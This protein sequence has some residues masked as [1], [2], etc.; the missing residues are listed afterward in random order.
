VTLCRLWLLVTV[1]VAAGG[2][3]SGASATPGDLDPS[4]SRD[5]FLRLDIGGRSAADAVAIDGAS[6][7]VVAATT[8][9]LSQRSLSVARLNAN[10]RL[11]RGFAHD[12]IAE[13]EPD[14]VALGDASDIGLLPDGRVVVAAAGGSEIVVSRL[15]ADGRPDPSFAGDGAVEISFGTP[16]GVGGIVVAADGT[17]SVAGSTTGV[18][19]RSSGEIVL[20]QLTPFGEL[21]SSYSGDGVATYRFPEATDS[22]A[23]GIALQSDGATLVA[24]SG[25]AGGETDLA[26]ARFEPDGDLDPTFSEDG[27]VRL[28][29][30]GD[31]D[32]SS[33]VALDSAGRA[34]LAGCCSRG[35]LRLE[36]DGDVDQTFAQGGSRG[37]GFSSDLL[38]LDAVDRINTIL[39][40]GGCSR[41]C[42]DRN[43]VLARLN[44]DGSVDRRFSGDGLVSQ[45][46][47]LHGDAAYD[48]AIQQNGRIVVVGQS[49]R[50]VLV[51]RHEVSSGK[52]DADG[53][54]RRDRAD[55]CPTRYG[56]TESGCPKFSRT[57][58]FKRSRAAD[59]FSGRLRSRDDKCVNRRRIEVRLELPGFD[60]ILRE[61]TT[62]VFGRW[63]AD[64]ALSPGVYYAMVDSDFRPQ[65]GKCG[66]ARSNEITIR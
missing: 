21:D 50:Q 57:L 30:E 47:A 19:D 53:D 34:V 58:S 10:G 15:L 31:P 39:N 63:K 18:S 3:T 37:Y 40:V 9:S 6:K 26:V 46:F 49:G 59:L 36:P 4:F 44:Q 51:A 41:G 16:V 20:A 7:I 65:I 29:A 64:A 55:R 27:S 32:L 17:T 48:M 61:V 12:G 22:D 2:V 60:K 54:R 52:P 24:G 45:D 14:L 11:D 25:G 33:D 66:E 56:R 62:D 43:Y 13:L 38:E 1:T 8:G 23:S 28:T 42:L 35:V 5:G